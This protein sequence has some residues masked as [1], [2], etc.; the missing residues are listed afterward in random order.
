M[1]FYFLLWDLFV[2][3]TTDLVDKFLRGGNDLSENRVFGSVQED[4]NKEH[5]H[6]ITDQ[7]IIMVKHELETGRKN[8]WNYCTGS[9]GANKAGYNT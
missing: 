8:I 2:V 9:N 1:N 7:D 6:D 4:D 5:N 3:G